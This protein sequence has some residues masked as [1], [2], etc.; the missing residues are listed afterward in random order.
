MVVA[1]KRDRRSIYDEQ[2]KRELMEACLQPKV[3][4][5]KVA[6]EC[7]VNANQLAT[8]GRERR[9]LQARP[10]QGVDVVEAA[11]AFLPVQSDATVPVVPAAASMPSVQARLPN[12]VVL[13]LQ[14]DDLKQLGKLIETLGRVRCFASTKG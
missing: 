6:R 2:A 9:R 11:A 8:W 14:C 5:G 1:H 10:S 7:G 12:G 3:S 13:D 4:L